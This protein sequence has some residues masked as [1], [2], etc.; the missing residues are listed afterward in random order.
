MNFDFDNRINWRVYER[1]YE[2]VWDRAGS[3]VH[4]SHVWNT[5]FHCVST[6]ADT[7][8]RWRLIQ[9]AIEEMNI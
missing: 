5:V 9:R 3:R 7:N 1:I 6:R 2:R 8:F 4:Y